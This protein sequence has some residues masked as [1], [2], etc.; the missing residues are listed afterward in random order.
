MSADADISL[1]VAG[2]YSC[3]VGGNKRLGFERK[4][5]FGVGDRREVAKRYRSEVV[6]SLEEGERWQKVARVWAVG[7]GG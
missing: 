5:A 4:V 2:G 6:L 1:G 3:Y 7:A